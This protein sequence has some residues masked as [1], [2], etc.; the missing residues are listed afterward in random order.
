[1]RY[2]LHDLGSSET[3]ELKD[4]DYRY[5]I[6]A[7]RHIVG[8]IIS[9]RNKKELNILYEYK[10]SQIS[11]NSATLTLQDSYEDICEVDKNLHLAWCVIDPKS[12]E[13]TLPMLSEIGVKKI[14]FIYCDR[15]QKSFKIDTDRL[16][17]ILESSMM[18]SGRTSLIELE[19]FDTLEQFLSKYS[20]VAILDFGGE[21][22]D[23]SIESVLIGCEG[24]FSDSERAS[25]GTLAR[26]RLDSSIILRSES[27]AVAI[28]SKLIL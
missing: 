3:I 9:I 8:D 21:A 6:K 22:I 7:R 17:R 14:S 12:I 5:I 1:M 4:D 16:N 15:S 24:G 19:L 11:K 20:D 26:V 18:Q 13:K 2:L 23:S 27:A 25:F 10:I 28:A